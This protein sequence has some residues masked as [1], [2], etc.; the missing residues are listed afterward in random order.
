[1]TDCPV[2]DREP[3]RDRDDEF[4]Y[5]AVVYDANGRVIYVGPLVP[6]WHPA[7]HQPPPSPPPDEPRS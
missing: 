6:P 3:E 1:M 7:R 2:P 4:I 5:T